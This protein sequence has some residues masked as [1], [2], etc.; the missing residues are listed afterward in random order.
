MDSSETSSRKLLPFV[1]D[2]PY[3]IQFIFIFTFGYIWYSAF[4]DTN[5]LEELPETE[6]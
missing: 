3:H 4:L 2:I 5:Y 1:P 6:L